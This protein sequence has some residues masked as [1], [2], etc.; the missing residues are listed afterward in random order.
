MITIESRMDGGGVG[1]K[2]KR[3]IL[4]WEEKEGARTW[5]LEK[6]VVGWTVH[7]VF[8]IAPEDGKN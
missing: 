7:V 6:P 8:K 1:G 5:R 3:G 4:D 2:T